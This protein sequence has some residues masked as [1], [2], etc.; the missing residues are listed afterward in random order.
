LCPAA[1][2]CA[3]SQ[4]QS[5][6]TE[7]EA[8]LLLLI[9]IMPVLLS[10]LLPP[11][12][13]SFRRVSGLQQ[14]ELETE[15]CGY[16]CLVCPTTCTS[17]GMLV[18]TFILTVAFSVTFFS[19]LLSKH[20]C[21]SPLGEC[22]SIS[23]VC[24]NDYWEG[25]VFMFFTLCTASM[26]VVRAVARLRAKWPAQR[27]VKAV[28]IAGALF[29]SFTGIF[30]EKSPRD[31]TDPRVLLDIGYKFHLAGI[32]SA[33]LLLV[34]LPAALLARW[35]RSMPTA[36]RLALLAVRGFHIVTILAVAMLY[37]GLRA[38]PRVGSLCSK[39]TT[40]DECGGWARLSP[41]RCD[42]LGAVPDAQPTD[43]LCGWLNNT[44]SAPSTYLLP[45]AYVAAHS[46]EC[47]RTE[48]HLFA[49]ARS[50]ALEFATLL[51]IATYV[52]TYTL[53]DVRWILEAES[54]GSGVPL[55][56]LSSLP[57]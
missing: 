50:M 1:T 49:F 4:C 47:R 15:L 2:D 31:V 55:S 44:L 53:A 10:L 14:P 19:L 18:V 52:G 3:H 6:V 5:R 51:L 48:C 23:C 21:S 27:L 38:T 30:P 42:A 46:G 22:G 8:T 13:R 33:G 28:L 17:S 41:A 56:S 39:L 7:L 26:V 24:G 43:Y 37:L 34:A 40:A 29:I 25:Y 20:P 45:D 11:L 12:A 57:E 32:A 54:I 9:T 16:G 36:P 35:T